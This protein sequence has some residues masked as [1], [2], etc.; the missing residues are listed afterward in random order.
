M[1]SR[2]R[3]IDV[4]T[5][6]VYALVGGL[7]ILLSDRMVYLMVSDP[8]SITRIQTTKGWAFVLGSALLIFVLLRRD[9]AA[10]RRTEA[11]LRE[12]E[13]R[14]RATIEATPHIAVQWYDAQGRVL[15]WNRASELIYGWTAAE[16]AGK[17]LD[18]LIHTPEEEAG[19]RELLQAIRTTG[20]PVEPVELR[21]TRRDGSEGHSLSTTFALPSREGEPSFV[22]MDV[23]I[24]DRR[25]A[26]EIL[27]LHRQELERAERALALAELGTAIAHEVNQPLAAIVGN[28]QAARRFLER[29]P[30][31]LGEV[32]QALRE[33]EA[34][35]THAGEVIRR[36]RDL[37]RRRD[38][39]REPLDLNQLCRDVLRLM[40]AD[41][42]RRRVMTIARL[43]PSLPAVEG[44]PVAL[45]Q[46]LLNLVTNAFEA[47]RQAGPTDREVTVA[48]RREEDGS[49]TVTVSDTG[50]GVP[51]EHLDRLFEPF[52][53]T[54]P[55]GLGLGLPLSRTLVRAHGGEIWARPGRD[56]GLEVAFRLPARA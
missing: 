24:T 15:Y 52:F 26:E 53:T 43:D 2:I 36:Q 22:C 16:A 17:T 10:S 42:V 49:V 4:R 33:I 11:A 34:A 9:L 46:V 50:A 40:R 45:Q 47:A 21:F 23:E 54:K 8:D 6:L 37:L 7:Y 20:R 41:A 51:P 29:D 30:P 56:G 19:F 1:P 38:V 44:D 18:Q 35:G 48:S 27:R 39:R 12:S 28:A 55:D 25:R 5:A 14:L 13:E 3:D 31:D 32:R